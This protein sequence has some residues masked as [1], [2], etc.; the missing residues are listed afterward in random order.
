MVWITEPTMD[1]EL[2]KDLCTQEFRV[3]NQQ[4]YYKIYNLSGILAV[5]YMVTLSLSHCPKTTITTISRILLQKRR[6]KNLTI[7]LVMIYTMCSYDK[8]IYYGHW[9]STPCIEVFWA[10]ISYLKSDV[11]LLTRCLNRG[12]KFQRE[13]LEMWVTSGQYF[14]K[15]IYCLRSNL[16]GDLL[17]CIKSIVA[18]L[19]LYERLT[20]PEKLYV[21]QTIDAS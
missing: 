10:K 19:P 7:I 15:V 20:L 5:V 6:F 16:G 14:I 3:Y 18:T 2:R 12:V 1:S 8:I 21:S 13:I 17:P 9:I 4:K 11:R